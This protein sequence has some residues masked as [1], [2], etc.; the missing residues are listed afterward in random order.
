MEKRLQAKREEIKLPQT[1]QDKAM[2]RAMRIAGKVGGE[3]I[4]VKDNPKKLEKLRMKNTGM[5]LS[6]LSRLENDLQRQQDQDELSLSGQQ[7]LNKL[8]QRGTGI[9]KPDD[10]NIIDKVLDGQQINKKEMETTMPD[11][12]LDPITA[13]QMAKKFDI[14]KTQT[15]KSIQNQLNVNKS[16]ELLKRLHTDE[17]GRIAITDLNL[18][19]KILHHPDDVEVKKIGTNKVAL[20]GKS[21]GHDYFRILGNFSP[22][23]GIPLAEHIKKVHGEDYQ[24][25]PMEFASSIEDEIEEKK[26]LKDIKKRDRERSRK[27]QK[28]A[29]YHKNKNNNS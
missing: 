5:N 4:K 13:K 29:W 2:M 22:G 17:N 21:S 26:E 27:A 28:L 24:R 7:R 16:K 19:E 14:Y 25:E 20:V 1:P 18:Q 9:Y 3:E 6:E 15:D 12:N 8:T 10:Q 23:T 11:K